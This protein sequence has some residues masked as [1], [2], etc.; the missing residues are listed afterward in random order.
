MGKWD[1]NVLVPGE[2]KPKEKTIPELLAEISAKQDAIIE[3]L[4]AIAENTATAD[5]KEPETP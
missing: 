2:P 1:R 3:K 4:D 5:D